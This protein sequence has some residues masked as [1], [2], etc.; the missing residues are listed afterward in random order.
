MCKSGSWKREVSGI[1]QMEKQR[2]QLLK[3]QKRAE[4]RKQNREA[5]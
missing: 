5:Q 2:E 4:R 3:E 1:V